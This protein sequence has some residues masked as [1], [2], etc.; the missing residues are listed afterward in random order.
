MP[1][2]YITPPLTENAGEPLSPPHIREFDILVT[3]GCATEPNTEPAITSSHTIL[4][5]P[6]VHPVVRPTLSTLSPVNAVLTPA[7]DH[8]PVTVIDPPALLVPTDAVFA[9]TLACVVPLYCT[10]IASDSAH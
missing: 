3:H 7:I 6:L 2:A 1:K 4:T 5:G 10:N 8:Q 9:T